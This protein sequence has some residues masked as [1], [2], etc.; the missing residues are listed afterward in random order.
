MRWCSF[1]VVCLFFT[2]IINRVSSFTVKKGEILLCQNVFPQIFPMGLHCLSEL[3][4]IQQLYYI[5]I[6]NNNK[7]KDTLHAH[8][9]EMFSGFF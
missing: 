4:T 1:F 8:Y 2:F 5:N 9:P 7:F 6:N 3:I